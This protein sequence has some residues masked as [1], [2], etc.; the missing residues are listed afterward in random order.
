MIYKD[1][2][3]KTINEPIF[4]GADIDN[5]D[6][7][8]IF[9]LKLGQF[10]QNSIQKFEPLSD[11]YKQHFPVYVID[12]NSKQPKEFEFKITKVRY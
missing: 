3:T 12:E 7:P 1:E 4:D 8:E 11:D 5:P 9:Y 6:F 10:G 2:N